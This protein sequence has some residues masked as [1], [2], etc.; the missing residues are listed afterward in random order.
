MPP[1]ATAAAAVATAATAAAAIAA[2]AACL[3][4]FTVHTAVGGAA[5]GVHVLMRMRLPV[6]PHPPRAA[7]FDAPRASPR[8]LA[9]RREGRAV[10]QVDLTRRVLGQ[11]ALAPR[12]RAAAAE[13]RSAAG[14]GR[15]GIHPHSLDERA[16]CRRDELE[17]S[18]GGGACHRS[19]ER[20]RR[21]GGGGG[22]TAASAYSVVK[23][24]A[25]LLRFANAYPVA[26]RALA[27]SAS[28]L[29]LLATAALAQSLKR[30]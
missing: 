27:R 4:G 3:I 15:R 30:R 2:N 10:A 9:Q 16:R 24:V 7:P 17:R 6:A 12:G 25:P 23:A 11:R 29:M 18:C 22:G 8:G 13:T 26:A 28:V 21:D 1:A 20:A 19:V 14:W 5:S